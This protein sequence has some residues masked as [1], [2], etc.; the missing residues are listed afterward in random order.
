M[1]D[2]LNIGVDDREW[3]PLHGTYKWREEGASESEVEREVVFWIDSVIVDTKDE[4]K[5]LF[6]VKQNWVS[7]ESIQSGLVPLA[8]LTQT[9][10]GEYPWHPI[11]EDWLE[12]TGQAIRGAP[13]DTE[14]AII[15]LLWEAEYDCSIDESYGMYVPSPYLSDLLGLEWVVDEKQFTGQLADSVRVADLYESE[16]LLDRVNSLSMIGAS[17]NLLEELDRE[18]L[19]MVWL[20][21]GEKRVS[22]GTVGGNQF[23]KSQIRS[24]YSLDDDGQFTGEMETDFQSWD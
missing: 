4:A 20:V 3:L 17:R 14:K 21:Q 15:D 10:R 19:S 16:G 13:V 7:S 2:L 18:G 6:W 9:F 1:S 8:I 5:L 11:I 12:D 23:G 24:V 22:A